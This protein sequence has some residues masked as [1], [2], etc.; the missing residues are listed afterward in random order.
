[1]TIQLALAPSGHYP[2]VVKA[3]NAFDL[4]RTHLIGHAGQFG[5]PKP[6]RRKSLW[7]DKRADRKNLVAPDSG[8]LFNNPDHP[9]NGLRWRRHERYVREDV[10]AW[11]SIVKPRPSE[12]VTFNMEIWSFVWKP[13]TDRQ[14]WNRKTMER[15]HAYLD[16]IFRRT[17]ET[18]ESVTACWYIGCSGPFFIRDYTDAE[19]SF[20][21][22]QSPMLGMC[23]DSP[24]LY[25][26][27]NPE[28][29][30]RQM[31]AAPFHLTRIPFISPYHPHTFTPVSK[32]DLVTQRK[33]LEDFGTER[34]DIFLNIAQS[35]RAGVD[36]AIK[37]AVEDVKPMLE[38][39]A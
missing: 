18:V 38:V 36:A 35:T 31:A 12:R 4:P 26:P 28:R 21:H 30:H 2:N 20:A 8:F 11:A 1:M 33:F 5:G 16:A 23:S 39:F 32:N 14:W 7:P 19:L 22:N 25:S 27:S 37:Q 17:A 10:R 13:P 6:D 15:H 3:F 34:A 9:F 24:Q 29:W